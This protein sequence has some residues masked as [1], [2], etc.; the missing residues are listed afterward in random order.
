MHDIFQIKLG[1][2]FQFD[3]QFLFPLNSRL[4]HR[5]TSRFSSKLLYLAEYR[6]LYPI[7]LLRGENQMNGTLMTCKLVQ[8]STS[9]LLDL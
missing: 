1:I 8:S 6:A 2:N 3:I 4:R 5:E 7:P 9:L